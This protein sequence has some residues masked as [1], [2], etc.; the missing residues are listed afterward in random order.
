MSQSDWIVLALK[1][2]CIS[3][4]VSLTGWL[5]QY[6]VYTKGGWR[7]NVIGRTLVAKTALIACLLVPTTLSLFFQFNRLTSYVAGWVDVALI[8]LITP[9]MF[10]R[11][12]V[13]R[14]VHKQ[15]GGPDDTTAG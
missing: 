11:A 4:F 13:W 6:H 9:V 5:A 8:G 15:P 7:R 14:H 10:W 12:A 1:I 3:G 2:V